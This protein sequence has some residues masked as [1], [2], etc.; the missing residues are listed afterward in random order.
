M[1]ACLEKTKVWH[2]Y[3]FFLDGITGVINFF[4]NNQ[5]KIILFCVFVELSFIT[6]LLLHSMNILHYCFHYNVTHNIMIPGSV[7]LH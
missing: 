6:S 2:P 4:S 5:N 7:M 1:C 3:I